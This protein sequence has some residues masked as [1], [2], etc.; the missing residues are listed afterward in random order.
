LI[1]LISHLTRV[2][3][4]PK[5]VF[6]DHHYGE[7]K[8]WAELSLNYGVKCV[9]NLS[10]SNIH[11]DDGSTKNLKRLYSKMYKKEDYVVGADMEHILQ[12]LLKHGKTKAVGSYY[13]NEWYW[14][15]L[16]HPEEAKKLYNQRTSIERSNAHFKNQ[17]HIEECLNVR[18]L[19]RV[20]MYVTTFWITQHAI[21]LAR[22]QH[23][24]TT[25]LDHSNQRIFT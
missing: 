21:A 22:L 19:P 16:A 23:G 3:I 6:G 14:L 7:L 12:F 18:T 25:E 13:R 11:R 8:N 24:I 15:N 17:L 5:E 2:D 10:K 20:K 9:F 4:H 1:P